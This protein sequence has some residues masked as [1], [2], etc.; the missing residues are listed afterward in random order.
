M[1]LIVKYMKSSTKK[2]AKDITNDQNLNKDVVLYLIS[3]VLYLIFCAPLYI[4]VVF[5][6]IFHA[7]LSISVVLYLILELN[8]DITDDQNLNKDDP[9]TNASS[10]PY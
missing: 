1:I 10:D 2:G 7:P 4:S 9:F 6:L 8:K 3:V 5:Y